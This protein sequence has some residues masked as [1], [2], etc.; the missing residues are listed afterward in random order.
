MKIYPVVSN[1]TRTGAEVDNKKDDIFGLSLFFLP[2][3]TPILFFLIFDV[4]VWLR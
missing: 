2:K 1:D 3:Y 4:P